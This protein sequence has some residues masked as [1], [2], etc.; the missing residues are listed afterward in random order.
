MPGAGDWVRGIIVGLIVT[1]VGYFC[2]QAISGS[3][4]ASP[5]PTN[6]T[7]SPVRSG[8]P[9]SPSAPTNPFTPGSSQLPAQLTGTWK[10][11]VFQ[12]S[13]SQTYTV[14]L[15]LARMPGTA[16][17]TSSYPTLNCEG[18]LR[19]NDVSFDTVV[20]TEYIT[21]GASQCATPNQITLKYLD[22]NHLLYTFAY[23]GNPTDG[24]ATL[25]RSA[26]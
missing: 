14:I 15:E 13:T 23:S 5:T 21:V 22:K 12:A 10:G 7:S 8:G 19:L 20:I 18:M 1:V 2:I 6:T 16:I 17:G 4:K 9:S 26:G 11:S 3:P 25:A 24:Q